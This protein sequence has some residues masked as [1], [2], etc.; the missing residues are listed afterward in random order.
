MTGDSSSE[1]GVKANGDD[2]V[3]IVHDE[4]RSGTAFYPRKQ[5][6]VVGD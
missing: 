6:D 5:W 4:H 3:A 1:D 2:N